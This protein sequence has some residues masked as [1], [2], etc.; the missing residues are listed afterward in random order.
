MTAKNNAKEVPRTVSELFRVL[1][2]NV[3]ST[4]NQLHSTYPPV[5]HALNI[6]AANLNGMAAEIQQREIYETLEGTRPVHLAVNAMLALDH[7]DRV[8]FKA[9]KTWYGDNDES[10]ETARSRAELARY[11]ELVHWMKHTG[12]D[13][14]SGFNRDTFRLSEDGDKL[15]GRVQATWGLYY[16][17]EL[18]IYTNQ[19][20]VLGTS[21][22]EPISFRMANNEVG[23][24]W[25]DVELWYKFMRLNGGLTPPARVQA[26]AVIDL[27]NELDAD[28]SLAERYVPV[29]IQVEGE[30]RLIEVM[31]SRFMTSDILVRPQEANNRLYFRSAFA[32]RHDQWDQLVPF[33]QQELLKALPEAISIALKGQQ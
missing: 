25:F 18:N 32:N 20:T 30:Q 4:C 26:D 12:Q 5:S 29:T 7:K 22:F 1:A 27:W 13:I 17:V 3:S 24:S 16:A 6:L 11:A 31:F 21:S 33:I 15:H 9:R 23:M 2:E 28:A 19:V 14:N 10:I 8:D